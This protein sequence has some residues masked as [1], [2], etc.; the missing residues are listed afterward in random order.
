MIARA[1]IRA[2]PRQLSATSAEKPTTILDTERLDCGTGVIKPFHSPKSPAQRALRA[3]PTPCAAH[4][5]ITNRYNRVR[6][7]SPL[8]HDVLEFMLEGA[9]TSS[10]ES[11]LIGGATADDGKIGGNQE[12]SA[13]DSRQT[14][15]SPIAGAYAPRS[16]NALRSLSVA[17]AVAADANQNLSGRSRSADTARFAQTAACSANTSSSTCTERLVD[18]HTAIQGSGLVTK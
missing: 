10:Q 13:T 16:N 6:R 12:G 1:P 14:K 17:A 5:D 9:S 4:R 18:S 15:Q 3:S 8:C 2:D 11:L 7:R